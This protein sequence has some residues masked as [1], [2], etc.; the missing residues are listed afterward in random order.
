MKAIQGTFERF[1]DSTGRKRAQTSSVEAYRRLA[2]YEDLD[3]SPEEL[4][5]LIKREAEREAD[6]K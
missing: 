5:D 2:A 3:R 4:R 1:T 6:M